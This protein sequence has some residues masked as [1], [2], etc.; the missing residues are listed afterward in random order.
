MEICLSKLFSTCF[1][2]LFY[3]LTNGLRSHLASAVLAELCDLCQSMWMT[4]Y[5]PHHHTAGGN[6]TLSIFNLKGK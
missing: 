4:M 6:C 2:F 5:V 1:N 3:N